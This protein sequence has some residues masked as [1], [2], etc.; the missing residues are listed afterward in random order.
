M[1]LG[2]L[3]VPEYIPASNLN[4]QSKAFVPS[5]SA[6]QPQQAQTINNITINNFGAGEMF[7]SLESMKK[8]QPT[9]LQASELAEVTRKAGGVVPLHKK[10]AKNNQTELEK[11]T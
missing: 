5:Q 1:N 6:E 9:S 4:S 7:P 2:A 3:K 11:T 8:P 10:N